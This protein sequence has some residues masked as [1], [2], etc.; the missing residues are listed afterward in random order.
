MTNN[1]SGT[2]PTAPDAKASVDGK[3]CICLFGS[4]YLPS[5]GG[6]E[7]Y[8]AS[9]AGA[10][11]ERGLRVIIVTCATLSESGIENEGGIDVVRLP[12]SP[13]LGG[14]YP[15][16]RNGIEA[17][18]LW[19]WLHQQRIDFVEVHTRFYPLSIKALAFARGIGVT[20]VLLEHGSAHLTMGNALVDAGVQAVEHFMTTR[21]KRYP[22]IYYA[23]SQK[24][25]R[26]LRHFGIE[27]AGELPN[28]IDADAYAAGAS[29]RDFRAE[30]G[31]PSE[32]LLVSFIGRLVPEKGVRVLAQAAQTLGDAPITLVLGGDGPL[33]EDLR[34]HAGKRFKLVGRLDRPDVAAL[35]EQSD[36]MCLPSRSEGFATSLLEAAACETPSLVTNVGGTDELVPD[37]RFGTLLSNAEPATV[38]QALLHAERNRER[39]QDQ[40]RNV[41]GRVRERFS[42]QATAQLTLEACRKAQNH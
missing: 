41:A 11:R 6:V 14:R 38:A 2:I 36:L 17:N 1:A 21:C 10:L 26:W 18:R 20:P 27:S 24:G 15:V 35:L 37:E 40:G 29:N 16:P 13:L 23:V 7:N 32:D 12:C 42:W 5:M 31:I 3:T 8:T 30:L 9:L 39:L 22:A 33:M 19:E 4:M 28:S 34:Q 25:S